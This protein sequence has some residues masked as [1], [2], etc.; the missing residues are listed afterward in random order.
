MKIKTCIYLSKDLFSKELSY[1]THQLLK[2]LHASTI[3]AFFDYHPVLIN[4]E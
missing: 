3:L 1:S 2:I 4:S